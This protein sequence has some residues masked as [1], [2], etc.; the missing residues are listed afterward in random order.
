MTSFC[1]NC[2]EPRGK[3]FDCLSLSIMILMYVVHS[4]ICDVV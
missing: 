4:S 1:G 2:D 3:Y